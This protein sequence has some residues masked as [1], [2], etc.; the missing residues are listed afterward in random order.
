MEDG[1]FREMLY[2]EGGHA[3]YGLPDG[4]GPGTAK[5]FGVDCM[6]AEDLTTVEEE[7][8]FGHGGWDYPDSGGGPAGKCL[9]MLYYDAETGDYLGGEIV[10]CW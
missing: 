10:T 2:H 8:S 9:L 3:T 4:P 5:E 6:E 1:Q 7:V